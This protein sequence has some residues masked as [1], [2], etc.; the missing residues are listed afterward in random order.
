MRSDRPQSPELGRVI[1][2]RPRRVVPP[3]GGPTRTGG[4]RGWPAAPRSISSI[5]KSTAD[6]APNHQRNQDDDDYRHRMVVNIL[7]LL[8]CIML[9]IV[10]IWLANQIADMKRIQD[11]VLTGRSDCVPAGIPARSI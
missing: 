3:Q 1:A 10:G 2:F 11:C 6:E 4:G 7:G 9:S 8:V 5:R